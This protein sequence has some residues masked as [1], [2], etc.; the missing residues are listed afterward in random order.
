MINKAIDEQVVIRL[1]AL[2]ALAEITLG[3]VLHALRI[4]LTGL[5]VGS[6][7][8]SCVF[9]ISRSTSSYRT[10]FQALFTVMVIKM[11]A[12][13]HASPFSY[14]AMT[15]QTLCCIPL[16]GHR[17]RSRLWVTSMFLL[18]SLYS[19][20][21][22]LVILY[23]TFGQQGL[24]VVMDEFRKWVA[25]GL[26]GTEFVLIPLVVWFGTHLAA[27]FFLAKWLVNWTTAENGI[28]ELRDEW[29]SAKERGLL[30][31]DSQRPITHRNM[32]I[33]IAVVTGLCLLYMYEAVL[34]AWMHVLWRPL[35]IILFWQ[36][37]LRP[38]S[39]LIARKWANG[40]DTS[41]NVRA[42]MD[43]LPKMWSV[44]TF[45]KM[46]ASQA[47]GSIERFYVFIKVTLLLSV[48]NS[49]DH[50]ND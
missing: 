6:I 47:A 45:A 34:P 41:A 40:A 29:K 13:P 43:E 25:P 42:V 33:P 49:S 16:V 5:M 9:L 3:G 14:L 7:A 31:M 39:M 24:A 19:P 44:I 38:I 50:T 11:M 1:S 26:S 46:K 20:V 28:N 2:W 21:Q 8:L 12:T 48:K 37:I 4:P 10:L 35:L 32:L 27:G 23:V 30:A 15:A 36:L 18:A 17:G 22:K